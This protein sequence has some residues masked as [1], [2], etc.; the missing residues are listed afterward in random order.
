VNFSSGGRRLLAALW[1]SVATSAQ[2]GDAYEWSQ[3]TSQGLELR[4]ITQEAACPKATLDGRAVEMSMRAAPDAAFPILVCALPVPR[5]A[6]EAAI[7]DRPMPLGAERVDRIAVIGD[8]GCRLLALAMQRCNDPHEWPFRIVADAVADMGPQLVLHVGDLIYRERA[9]PASNKGCAGSPWGDNWETWKAEFFDPAHG[10]LAAAPLVFVRGNHE[11]CARNGAGWTRL[12]G[13]LPHT[14]GCAPQEPSYSVD[15]GGLT[16]A[17]LD[18]TR[19]EDRSVDTAT[20]PFFREQFSALGALPSPVWVAMHKGVYGSVRF[21]NG[22]NEGHNF[23]LGEAARGAMPQSVSA[24][25]SGHLHVFQALGFAEDVPAQIISGAAGDAL[26]S[27]APEDLVGRKL[28]DATVEKGLGVSTLFGF[29]MME[30]GANDW[31]VSHYD[32][33]ERL[34]ARCRLSGRKVACE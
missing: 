1:C 13:P 28:G 34:L 26:D 27:G 4:A 29:T 24:L 25:I 11:D 33:H 31:L 5:D 6:K 19:A 32:A 9:C 2:A 14:P 17:V 18:V 10:L 22:V 20:A 21:K 3:Y 16:L 7:R 12:L 8:T 30:R 23:T 15:L